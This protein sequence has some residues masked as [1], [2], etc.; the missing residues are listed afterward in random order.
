MAMPRVSRTTGTAFFHKQSAHR[1]TER[2]VELDGQVVRE[3]PT[4]RIALTVVRAMTRAV[5]RFHF[6]HADTVYDTEIKM[7]TGHYVIH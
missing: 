3:Y 5:S 6:L 2:G 4:P 7:E 1:F